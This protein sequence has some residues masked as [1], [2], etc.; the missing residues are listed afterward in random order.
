MS[1]AHDI[2]LA[3]I[4]DHCMRDQFHTVHRFMG[5]IWQLAKSLACE[6]HVF[7]SQW[8]LLCWPDF[9]IY[10]LLLETISDCCAPCRPYD[11]SK[12]TQHCWW[13]FPLR[14]FGWGKRKPH[15]L[16]YNQS[17]YK[18]LTASE[19]IQTNPKHPDKWT[20]WFQYNTPPPT[21]LRV[22]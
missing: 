11:T 1:N 20:Q 10:V 6:F 15:N 12:Q 4:T 19:D 21:L 9:T 3:P 18:R 13:S 2:E 14:I 7:H 16:N 5:P 17:S 8:F 22:A